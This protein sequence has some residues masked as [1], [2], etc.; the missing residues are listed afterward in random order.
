MMASNRETAT[1]LL[2]DIA[3]LVTK[4]LVRGEEAEALLTATMT[5]MAALIQRP[6]APSLDQWPVKNPADA[7]CL[8]KAYTGIRAFLTKETAP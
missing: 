5:D 8:Q 4:K 7:E 2:S 3:E 6:A 1:E